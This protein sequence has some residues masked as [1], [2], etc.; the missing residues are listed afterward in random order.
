MLKDKVTI[1]K[2]VRPML[3][4]H[5][6]SVLSVCLFCPVLSAMLVYSGQMAGWIKMKLGK[7]TG[8]LGIGHTVFDG[9][10][11]SLPQRG[12]APNFL[13]ISVVA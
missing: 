9:M 8:H 7:Q 4:D 11:L 12:T 5:Y 3:S 10:Q 13:P 6:L 2:M 1:F